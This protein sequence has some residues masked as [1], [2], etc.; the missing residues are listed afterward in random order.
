LSVQCRQL[1]ARLA[2]ILSDDAVGTTAGTRTSGER[3]TLQ[4]EM[5]RQLDARGAATK[6]E[7]LLGAIGINR[8]P[9]SAMN[10]GI[11]VK[12]IRASTSFDRGT[13]AMQPR[14]SPIRVRTC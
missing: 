1:I 5:R 13:E 11:K 8:K 14:R 4:R 12:I 9:A 2:L 7:P 3:L 6:A 10:P